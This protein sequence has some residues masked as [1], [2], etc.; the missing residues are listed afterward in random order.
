MSKRLLGFSIIALSAVIAC[1]AEPSSNKINANQAKALVMASLT[2][3]ERLL[4][5]LGADMNLNIQPMWLTDVL[6]KST[7]PTNC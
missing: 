6:K 5:S 4:P 3:K 7:M 1:A 2:S